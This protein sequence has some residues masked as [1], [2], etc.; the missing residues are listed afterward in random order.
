MGCRPE[1]LPAWDQALVPQPGC[2]ELPSAE[3]SRLTKVMPWP[4]GQPTCRDGSLQ[5]YKMP[6]GLPEHRS[7]TSPPVLRVSFPRTLSHAPPA[8]ASPSQSATREPHQRWRRSRDGKWQDTHKGHASTRHGMWTTYQVT[9][10]PQCKGRIHVVF[11]QRGRPLCLA[12]S[13]QR[14]E[15][16]AARALGPPPSPQAGC[17]GR[18]TMSHEG[19]AGA[20][21]STRALC[22]ARAVRPLRELVLFIASVDLRHAS[23]WSLFCK[24]G[25]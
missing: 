7:L 9:S 10:Y 1:T 3:E 15:A 6:W 23:L 22:P 25:N 8:H 18:A 2:L 20:W 4:Q 16:T 12:H 24:G 11:L 13:L 14:R 17:P 5:G 19:A 21:V